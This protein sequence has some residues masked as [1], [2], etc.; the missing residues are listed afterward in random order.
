MWTVK[1]SEADGSG[2]GGGVTLGS[3]RSEQSV[4]CHLS[5]YGL[6]LG[7]SRKLA[8]EVSLLGPEGKMWSTGSLK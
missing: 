8:N 4:T 1:D 6:T 3:Q 5:S 2:W 7:S